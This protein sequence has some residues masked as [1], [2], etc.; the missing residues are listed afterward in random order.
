MKLQYYCQ[1]EDCLI[2]TMLPNSKQDVEIIQ[3]DC[4]FISFNQP[5]DISNLARA[6]YCS[7]RAP[8]APIVHATGG[9]Y[10]DVRYWE[11]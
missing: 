3:F 10:G 4:T 1:K 2:C 6:I 11:G 7:Y 9:L 8:D 5:Q